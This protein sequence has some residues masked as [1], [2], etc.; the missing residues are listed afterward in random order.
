M[1]GIL[2][3]AFLASGCTTA[4]T[5]APPHAA[6]VSPIVGN[7]HQLQQDC[8]APIAELLFKR[9][10]TFHVTWVPFETYEDYWGAYRWDATSGQLD[11]TIANGNRVPT[12]VVGAGRATVSGEVL[13]FDGV[14]LGST[15]NG[16]ACAAPFHRNGPPP[17]N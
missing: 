11:L 9:D 1:R 17:V 5:T 3:A 15:E 2:L 12:D 4:A 6:S 8:A 10:G 14:S 13:T 7:W 16:A